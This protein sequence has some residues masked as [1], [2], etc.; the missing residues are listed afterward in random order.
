[1]LY[2]ENKN[3]KKAFMF[4]NMWVKSLKFLETVKA[5][6]DRPVNGCL[7]YTVTQRLKRLKDDISKKGA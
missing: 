3:G 5:I 4:F 7:M 2:T 1:M 6:W